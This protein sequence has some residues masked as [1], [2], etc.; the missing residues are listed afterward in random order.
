MIL[1][2]S[3][4]SEAHNRD[5]DDSG[6]GPWQWALGREPRMPGD[7][8]GTRGRLRLAE[9]GASQF[10]KRIALLETARAAQIKLRFGRR[11]RQLELESTRRTP[12][13]TKFTTG[14]I[15]CFYR[16]K[17]VQRKKDRKVADGSL[18]QRPRRYI[19]YRRW[20][21]P[22]IVIGT[23]G[24]RSV[25]AGYRGG[26]TK[27]APEHC[28]EPSRLEQLAAVEW[29]EHIA[30]L[31]AE[32]G[33]EPVLPQDGPAVGSATPLASGVPAEEAAAAADVAPLAVASARRR[34]SELVRVRM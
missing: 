21:G 7:I 29:S 31:V 16:E 1:G 11:L 8:L 5:T 6:H 32:L 24:D 27:C 26:V 12:E 15:V 2:A 9:H 19:Q 20:H 10:S 3:V 34:T 33:G 18:H 13:A 22:A 23:E 28:R 30:D 17:M 25:Y 4:C 14:T